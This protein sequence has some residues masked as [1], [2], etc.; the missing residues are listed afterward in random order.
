MAK[1]TKTSEPITN[2]DHLP[3]NV[4]EKRI[5]MIRDEQVMID[6]DLANIYGIENRSLRQAVRRNI[7]K[8]PDDFLFRLR[9]EEANMLILNGVSQNVIPPGYNTGGAEMFAFTEHGVA[10]LAT[11][12]KSPHAKTI[13]IAIIRAF[14]A[15]R[16]F[17]LSNAQVFQRLD[18]I[19][20]K[21]IE[22]DHRIEELFRKIDER[23]ITPKQGIFFDGQI[24]DAYEFICGII[25]CAK[26][27]I[28]LIDNYVDDTVLTMLD[29]RDAGVLA[30]IYTQKISRQFKLDI[31]KHNAQYPAID[32]KVF[33]KAHD[34]FLILD[35]QVYLIGASL[36]DL[37]KKWFAVS[38]MS[39]TD[40]EILISRL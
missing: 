13:S 38:L 21:Q 28:V 19:E 7:D 31:T 17:L 5:Y 23:S 24:Y 18:R 16:H 8:F 40:P 22:A 1:N 32:V 25:K 20:Y 29:K 3:I 10:M 26:T 35:N 2:C 34:R 33:R 12:L 11:I 4:I 30:T 39:E 6:I 37:G 27:R 15:M 9:G 14:V 36:K